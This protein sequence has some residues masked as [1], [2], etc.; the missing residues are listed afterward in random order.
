[1]VHDSWYCMQTAEGKVY[2]ACGC[3]FAYSSSNNAGCQIFVDQFV[4]QSPQFLSV[5][6][7]FL[8]HLPVLLSSSFPFSTNAHAVHQVLKAPLSLY[9][10][11]ITALSGVSPSLAG[12][13]NE[14]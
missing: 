9:S 7:C 1:M 3:F 10:L 2:S 4:D 5:Y 13:R 8:L 6:H 14:I 11:L 12:C